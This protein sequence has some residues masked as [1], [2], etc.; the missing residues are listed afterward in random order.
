M[1]F[2]LRCSF[3]NQDK[4]KF[5]FVTYSLLTYS[6]IPAL[7]FFSSHIDPLRIKSRGFKAKYSVFIYFVTVERTVG[8]VHDQHTFNHWA[9]SQLWDLQL[10]KASPLLLSSRAWGSPWYGMSSRVE[11]DGQQK[12]TCQFAY[13]G[14]EKKQ[15]KTEW[16]CLLVHWLRPHCRDTRKFQSYPKHCQTVEMEMLVAGCGEGCRF[17]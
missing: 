6:F 2:G 13:E 4:I 14:R 15:A 9:L 11:A 3:W 12:A 5:Y 16:G 1:I 10:N 7:P 17:L 8:F